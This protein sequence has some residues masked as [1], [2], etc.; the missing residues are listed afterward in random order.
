MERDIALVVDESVK[1]EDVERE[2]VAIGSPLLKQ[3]VLFDLYQGEHLEDGKESLA[4]SLR[5]QDP[6]KT[7][8]EEE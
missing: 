1:S 3:V 2:I 4:F 7:L 5:Y 6:E 8:T